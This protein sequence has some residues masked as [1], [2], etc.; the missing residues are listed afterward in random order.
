MCRAPTD[1]GPEQHNTKNSPMTSPLLGCDWPALLPREQYTSAVQ[2]AYRQLLHRHQ[3]VNMYYTA[4]T[5]RTVGIF[6]HWTDCYDSVRDYAGG[7]F[8]TW[9]TLDQAVQH[10]NQHG[11]KHPAIYV[12]ATETATL[13]SEYCT[14]QD[15]QQKSTQKW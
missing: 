13:L 7:W 1:R 6:I 14:V 5:G 12:H 9:G 8:R 15:I 11:I 3:P 4:T 2:C 10:L